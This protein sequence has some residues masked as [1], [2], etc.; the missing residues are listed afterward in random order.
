MRNAFSAMRFF[1]LDFELH[2]QLGDNKY[3]SNQ[4]GVAIV[5]AS[6]CSPLESGA[7]PLF[8]FAVF[9][10]VTIRSLGNTSS[11]KFTCLRRVRETSSSSS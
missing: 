1:T 11:T 2:E 5:Q 8:A 7:K 6:P 10:P 3:N 9:L 4:I